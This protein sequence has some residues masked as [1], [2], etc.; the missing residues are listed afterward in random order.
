MS[1]SFT[2]WSQLIEMWNIYNG[3]KFYENWQCY[4]YIVSKIRTELKFD[5]IETLNHAC[6]VTSQLLYVVIGILFQ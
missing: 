5:S 3:R 6:I 4:M 2:V 1:I